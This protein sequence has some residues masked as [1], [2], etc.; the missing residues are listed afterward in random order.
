MVY[1]GPASQG[2]ADE[3]PEGRSERQ[4]DCSWARLGAE[5]EGRRGSDRQRSPGS[6][7]GPEGAEEAAGKHALGGRRDDGRR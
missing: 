7:G 2:G 3:D 4:G 6:S 5:L 1:T